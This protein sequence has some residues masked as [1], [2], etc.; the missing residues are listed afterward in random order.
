MLLV[1]SKKICIAP[2]TLPFR[3]DHCYPLEDTLR[4]HPKVN[5]FSHQLLQLFEQAAFVVL[6]GLASASIAFCSSADAVCH[7]KEVATA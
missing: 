1:F 7:A 5:T 2:A 3:Q 6:S 4:P